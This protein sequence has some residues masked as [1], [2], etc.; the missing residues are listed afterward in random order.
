MT[1]VSR[2]VQRLDRFQQRRPVLGFAYAVVRKYADDDGGREAA[3]I[4]YYGFL[5]MFPALLLAQTVVVRVLHQRP[6]L[7]HRVVAAMV[8]PSLQS[9]VSDAVASLPTA[10]VAVAVA[11]GGLVLSGAGVVLAAARTLNHLAAVPYRLRTFT[12][13]RPVRTVAALALVL[14]G[15]V[16][17]GSLAVI[18]AAHPGR[19]GVSR[20][21]LVA[22]EGVT[23]C[24]VLLLAARLLLERPAPVR[25]LWPAAVPGAVAVTLTLE[26]GA[27]VLPGLVRRAGPIYG[28]FATVAAMFTLLYLLS[29]AL[30]LAAEV[31]AV[32]RARLWP[33]AVDRSRPVAADVRALGLLAREQERIPGQRVES[34]LPRP[35]DE[36]APG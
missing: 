31:A 2:I 28:A 3:L 19:P 33:R 15:T 5:S 32:H 30:V 25:A 8:P 36:R 1:G 22:G 7:R 29:L 35:P 9:T 10:P 24:A 21:M 6:P 34:R 14:A 27:A 13:W 12:P 20:M 11:L 17:V 26:L 18:A 23:A 4:T 16:T